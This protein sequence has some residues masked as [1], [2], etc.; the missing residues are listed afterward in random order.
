MPEYAGIFTGGTTYLQPAKLIRVCLTGTL[1]VP[2]SFTPQADIPQHPPSAQ[3]ALPS[4]FNR[5]ESV[6]E[7]EE[8]FNISQWPAYRADLFRQLA[9]VVPDDELEKYALVMS[10]TTQ[11]SVAIFG[12]HVD[13]I[14]EDWRLGPFLETLAATLLKYEV[15]Q[16]NGGARTGPMG[17]FL[18]AYS[19]GFPEGTDP[20][21]IHTVRAP[22]RF[23]T[24]DI[25]QPGYECVDD[26]SAYVTLHPVDINLRTEIFGAIGD[27]RGLI[28]N[29]GSSETNEEHGRHHILKKLGGMINGPYQRS[30]KFPLMFFINPHKANE[31]MGFYDR[32]LDEWKMK[33]SIDPSVQHALS[34]VVVVSEYSITAPF[35]PELNKTLK[36]FGLIGWGY[37]KEYT[38]EVICDLMELC[39]ART[40]GKEPIRPEGIPY[41]VFSWGAVE[42][43][44]L[45]ARKV[46]S[47]LS[48]VPEF[49]IGE[50]AQRTIAHLFTSSRYKDYMPVGAAAI[51]KNPSGKARVSFGANSQRS[52]GLN[53]CSEP[54]ALTALGDGDSLAAIF[55]AFPGG[56]SSEP[57]APCG[58]CREEILNAARGNRD[59]PVYLLKRNGKSE[60]F[61]TVTLGELL[62]SPQEMGEKVVVDSIE[63]TCTLEA[64]K[65]VSKGHDNL[66][67]VDFGDGVFSA[68]V[69]K[70]QVQA[71]YTRIEQEIMRGNQSARRKSENI[72]FPKAVVT[73]ENLLTGGLRH[74]LVDSAILLGWDIDVYTVSKAGIY[75]TC[76]SKLL[77]GMSGVR[78]PDNAHP[79]LREGALAHTRAKML[80]FQL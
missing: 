6:E 37:S 50:I 62:P 25:T 17:L 30:R 57:V 68:R 75:R 7:L 39:D 49:T 33:L 16:I 80:E 18:R 73:K 69:R 44:P 46:H 74:C 19:S 20:G 67:L 54:V 4:G 1:C 36:E 63:D 42:T 45:T 48:I 51:I 53:I 27:P 31:Y 43:A 64:L 35:N 56:S 13:T 5:G 61:Y 8:R 12:G 38:A 47:S 77:P 21:K 40:S 11:P 58:S 70:D 76:A 78:N 23:I 24:E 26:D 14:V 2:M 22:L 15:M 66:C 72:H 52:D 59:L 79:G 55:I 34:S 60:A 32:E 28:Y 29:V 65:M 71:A 41:S 9:G 3:P 10:N